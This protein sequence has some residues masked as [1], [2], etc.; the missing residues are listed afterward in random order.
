MDLLELIKD[1]IP[2][3]VRMLI[4]IFS[5]LG[6]VYMFGRLLFPS[7]KDKSKNRIAFFALLFFSFLVTL[8]KDYNIMLWDVSNRYTVANYF[9]DSIIYFSLG[10]VF[11]VTIGWRWYSRVD[12]FL[13][14]RFGK[15]SRK[16][17]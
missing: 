11:Y 5:T 4:I 2:Y 17:Q 10:A 16:R 12:D 3:M 9:L 1:Y 7:L 15:D 14:K 6:V 13:D 8:F